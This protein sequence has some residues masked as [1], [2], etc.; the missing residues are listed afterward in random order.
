M[1]VSISADVLVLEFSWLI[2][3]STFDINNLNKY[4]YLPAEISGFNWHLS[5]KY[6]TPWSGV[7]IE[8]LKVSH[9]VKKLLAF[10]GA[11]KFITL[12]TNVRHFILCQI[13]PVHVFPSCPFRSILILSCHV[14]LGFPG[15]LFHSSFPTKIMYALLFSVYLIWPT[16]FVSLY[17]IILVIFGG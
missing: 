15:G 1:Y 9:L 2:F 7:L 3:F 13:T 10:Y 6:L 5:K 14:H 4:S 8:K 11:R 12:F 16:H 17:L